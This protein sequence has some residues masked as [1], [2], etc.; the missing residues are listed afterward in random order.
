MHARRFLAGF[1]ILAGLSAPAFAQDN[2]VAGGLFA[3]IANNEDA[4]RALLVEWFGTV[5]P[6]HEPVYVDHL[7]ALAAD[8]ALVG[9]VVGIT[10]Q[11]TDPAAYLGG[12]ARAAILDATNVGVTRLSTE[13]Q[14]AYYEFARDTFAWV[15]ANQPEGCR[16]MLVGGG[17]EP[18]EDAALPYQNAYQ[19]TL[20]A[21]AVAVILDMSRT[22]VTATITDAAPAN[23]FTDAQLAEGVDAYRTA[24]VAGINAA[25]NGTALAAAAGRLGEATP[26]EA[27]AIGVISLDVLVDLPEPQRGYAIQALAGQM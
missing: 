14:L 23:N 22:A 10:G 26:E 6:E 1:A 13:D 20:S 2:G 24:L 27:C 17:N 19:S 12:P 4:A 21:D 9:Y 3:E 5:P 18:G 25:P 15:A 7:Q 11:P 8:P 16:T